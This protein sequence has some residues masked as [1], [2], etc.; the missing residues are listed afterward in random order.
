MPPPPAARIRLCTE[1]DRGTIDRRL[2][3]SFVEHM[4]RCVYGGIYQPDHPRADQSGFREDVA[5]LIGELGIGL[6]RYP[7]GNFVS[8]Y[9]WEDGVGPRELRPTTLDLAWRSVETNQ[10]GTDEFLQWAEGRRLT[11]MMAVNL[12]TR[13]AAEAAALVEY[14]NATSPTRY[15]DLRR[16]HGR[17]DPYDVGLWCL[18]NEMDGPWQIGHTTAEEYGRRAA[19]AGRA[20]RMVDPSI[21]LTVCGSSNREMASYGQW[22][23]TVLEHTHDLVD[24]LSI[25]AYYDGRQSDA[26]YLASG[27]VMSRYIE[28]LTATADAVVARHRS[29]KRLAIAFDEW[30]V[31]TTTPDDTATRRDDEIAVRPPLGEDRYQTLDAVVV[32]DLLISLLNHSD[33]VRVA[34]LSLLVNVSAPILTR[35][36]GS[37]LRQ[38]IFHP[39]AQTARLARGCSLVSSVDGPTLS[40]PQHGDV[41]GLAVAACREGDQNAIFLVNRTGEPLPVEIGVVDR[42]DQLIMEARTVIATPQRL[43]AGDP[44]TAGP[45]SLDAVAADGAVMA[46]LPA[47]SW[48]VIATRDDR[49]WEDRS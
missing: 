36:D 6:V 35:A 5:E 11:P 1:F 26:D 23:Q 7:G 12:G 13:G 47:R 49:G 19:A 18:G 48:S 10:V 8:G 16:K 2:F 44:E 37:V 3:G 20:M 38:T 27:E 40:S 46:T 28:E 24:Y 29:S 45:G 31:W 17:A 43:A 42:P 25:H 30:N 39:L 9:R 33:R 15:A 14:C 41:P 32:G 34:C 21:E 22:E 4:G